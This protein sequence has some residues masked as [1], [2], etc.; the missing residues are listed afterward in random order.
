MMTQDSTIAQIPKNRYF[1]TFILSVLLDAMT[2]KLS[3]LKTGQ[4]GIIRNI[5]LGG[6][7]RKRILEMGFV[8]GQEILVVKNAPLLDPIEYNVMGYDVSLRRKEACLIDVEPIDPK[9]TKKGV[10]M[11][12]EIETSEVSNVLDASSDL[13][14]IEQEKIKVAFLGNPNCGKT[15]LFN[16]CCGAHEHVGNYS[17]VTVD[18]KYGTCQFGSK[19]FT[20]ID[21]PG[22]YSLASYSPEEK[23]I[24]QFLVGVERPDIIV[25]IVDASNLERNLYLTT[26]LI[27]L[28]IPV[29][30]ALNMYDEFKKSKSKLNIHLLSQLLG[31]PIIPTIAKSGEGK[32]NLFEKVLKVYHGKSKISRKVPIP[33]PLQVTNYIDQLKSVLPK[34]TEKQPI[35]AKTNERLIATKLL[36]GDPLYTELVE[37]DFEKGSF[38][39]TK[40]RFLRQQ[41]E[42]EYSRDI[43]DVIT[44]TRYGFISGALRETFEGHFQ[45]LKGKDRKIDYWLTHKW[46]GFPIFLL[47]M[48]LMF[49]ATFTL[50]QYPMDWIESGFAY[51]SSLIDTHMPSGALKDLLSQGVIGG[52][53]GVMVFLPNI[54]ILY[55]FIAIME[56]TGYMAR[57]AFIMDRLMHMLGLHGKSFIPLIMGFGCNVPAIMS[58]R[59][60]E[61]RN[62]RLIT[63]LILP[64]M[65]CSARLPVY[66][67][68]AGAFFQ[69]SAGFVVF[70]IYLIGIAVAV[71]TALLLRKFFF[72]EEDVPFVMELPPYRRPQTLSVLMH[73]WSKAKQYLKKMGTVILLASIVIWA[74]GYFPRQQAIENN[75]TP[76]S[77][78]HQAQSFDKVV[79]QVQETEYP[80]EDND[81]SESLSNEQIK[82]MKQQ[83]QSYIGQMG[84]LVEPIFAPMGYDWKLSVALLSGLAAKEVVVSTMG[85]LYTGD[86]DNA[87]ISLPAKLS[88]SKKAD[89]T[90]LYSGATAF[91]F[92]LFVL[93][94]FPCVATVVAIGKEADSYKWMLF[95]IFYSCLLAWLVAFV[96]YQIGILFV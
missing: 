2:K 73:M 35:W 74:L 41:Y 48:Y 5:Q 83:E 21:L 37:N 68:L 82:Q 70:S 49:Q 30:M 22:T 89:G 17:G 77:I 27:E 66:I 58:T 67:L 36:E 34:A 64:F 59:T 40:A 19:K 63:I 95:S 26:Q 20:I 80:T 14:G 55:L 46:L 3:D 92:M 85:V 23:F 87:E 93:I 72:K 39:N 69:S 18:S 79:A 65:S 78:V 57:A 54:M 52:V 42:K 32:T 4:K 81:K 8:P 90:P 45:Q 60:I 91:S 75:E 10:K 44:D 76:T 71:V 1:T 11:L 84:K 38:L 56:D 6:R 28:D 31:I 88:S 51:L 62:S 86:P 43:S 33:Y 47:F 7:F 13:S 12:P 96:A 16:S 24:E 50:G 61:S 29:V 15:S 94:Y 53:G 9:S 25:N